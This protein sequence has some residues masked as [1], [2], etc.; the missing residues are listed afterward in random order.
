LSLGNFLKS[1][2]ILASETLIGQSL[3]DFVSLIGNTDEDKWIICLD[4]LEEGQKVEVFY[5]DGKNITLRVVGNHGFQRG[6]SFQYKYYVRV[7]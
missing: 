2:F 4:T 7:M 6:S 5:P 1:T 3:S